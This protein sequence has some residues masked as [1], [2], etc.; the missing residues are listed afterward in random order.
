MKLWKA[1]TAGIKN[2]L[3][4]YLVK[5]GRAALFAILVV[6]WAI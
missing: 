2:K 5:I 1:I 6:Q 3:D 4:R